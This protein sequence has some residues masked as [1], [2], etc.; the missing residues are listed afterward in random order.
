MPHSLFDV[1]RM[2]LLFFIS[3][4]EAR[5]R[6]LT[7][8]QQASI[9]SLSLARPA[10]WLHLCRSKAP[11]A[12]MSRCMGGVKLLGA[13]RIIFARFRHCCQTVALFFPQTVACR[14]NKLAEIDREPRARSLSPHWPSVQSCVSRLMHFWELA[15]CCT[16]KCNP[17]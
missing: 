5:S 7:P 12:Q 9:C 11:V 10:R 6:R 4:F 15:S 2:E 17:V 1:W 3:N 14:I 13:E 16:L 8:R